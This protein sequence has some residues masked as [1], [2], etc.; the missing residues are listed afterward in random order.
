MFVRVFAV[1]SRLPEYQ[2]VLITET[3]A[4]STILWI[5]VSLG[6]SP[7][8]ADS[9]QAQSALFYIICKVTGVYSNI[10]R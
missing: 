2:C 8:S 1:D 4:G 5:S 7:I 3:A 9:E 6:C 10:F